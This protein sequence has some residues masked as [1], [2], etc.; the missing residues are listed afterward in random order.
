[1]QTKKI[2]LPFVLSIALSAC[3]ISST[4]QPA[5]PSNLQNTP[6]AA[7]TVF[8]SPSPTIVQKTTEQLLNIKPK[9]KMFATL[10]TNQG[11]ITFELFFNQAPNTVAN[12]VGLAEGTKGWIDPKTNQSMSGKP[13]YNGL[14]FHRVIKD[15]M[16]QGGD[17]LGSGMGGPGYKFEDEFDPELTF[18]SAGILAMAN[19]GAN[20]NGSQFFITHAPTPW[21]NGKHTIFGKVTTGMD[22]VDKIANLTTD[23]NDRPVDPIIIESV[24]ITRK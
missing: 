21:L 16:I 12:F 15:F 14:V 10:N 18:D 8:L 23:A 5:P 22:V 19:S 9:Q 7:P 3:Q 1:M 6:T 13:F 11:K 2:I 4:L 20:T 24:T 17:P